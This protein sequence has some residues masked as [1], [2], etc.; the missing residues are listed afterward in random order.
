MRKGFPRVPPV[1]FVNEN[2]VPSPKGRR[3]QVCDE[4]SGSAASGTW[5]P[6][7]KPA[8][9]WG[10]S[11]RGD[12]T[13]PPPEADTT[14]VRPCTN[15]RLQLVDL[16][17]SVR[18]CAHVQIHARS[19]LTGLSP[20][21]PENSTPTPKSHL[22]PGEA[23]AG[24]TSEA[25]RPWV[26]PRGRPAVPLERCPAFWGPRASLSPG[27]RWPSRQV[28]VGLYLS[29]CCWL[30]GP[31]GHLSSLAHFSTNTGSAGDGGERPCPAPPGECT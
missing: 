10:C 6:L 4:P 9:A 11:R 8:L 2:A 19:H 20:R 29:S 12:K 15:T 21:G 28:A 18:V 30:R 17:C 27:P 3:S 5:C 13:D 31:P 23:R 25:S 14:R 7:S 22:I 1:R 26:G 24:Q 16:H